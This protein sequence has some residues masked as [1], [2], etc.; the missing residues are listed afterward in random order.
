MTTFEIKHEKNYAAEIIEVK[1]LVELPGL[2]NLV[3]LPWAGYTALVPRTT[4]VGDILVIFPA[5][6]QLSHEF[7]SANNLYRHSENNAD[8]EAVGY[9]EDNRRVRAIKL[10]GHRSSALALSLGS[11]M[12]MPHP[13]GGGWLME[14][15]VYDSDDLVGTQF[16][17]INGVEISR[18]YE[19]SV[20]ANSTAGKSQQEKMWRR[21]DDKFLPE[22]IETDNW[23][24]NEFKVPEDAWITVSQKIHGTSWRGGQVIVKRHLTWLERLAKRFGVKVPE[25]EY[26]YVFGSR[27]VIKDPHNE[28]QQH[29]YGSDLWT[30][31]GRTIE[32]LLPK[33]VVVYGELVGYT[34]EGA[35]IQTGYT[36]DVTEDEGMRLYVYRVVVVTEDGVSYDLPRAGVEQFCLERGLSIV[37]LLWQGFK[38]DFVAEDWLDKNYWPEYPQAVPLSK[39]SVC[40]EGVVIQVEGIVPQNYKHKSPAFLGFETQLLDKDVEVLS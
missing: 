30:E 5:E 35:P 7:A 15:H 40:D 11:I 18:K 16:D 19:L 37:P 14:Q 31:F 38:R 10:R 3:G 23:M 21:V 29:H 36:Y 2:D 12:T 1:G 9:L 20:K 13:K 32:H 34:P 28:R 24:R 27:K 33:G 26:D 17:T 4:Q 6:A 39:D 8:P 22:H 25:T